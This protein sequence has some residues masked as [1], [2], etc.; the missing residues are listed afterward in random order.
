M[1]T[2]T[3]ASWKQGLSCVCIAHCRGT[4]NHCDY[5]CLCWLQLPNCCNL[6]YLTR[7]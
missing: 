5:G 6:N 4:C 1:Q 2:Y 7:V 3:G